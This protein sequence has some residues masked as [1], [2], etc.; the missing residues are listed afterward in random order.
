[1]GKE[2]LLPDVLHHRT[3]Q[4]NCLGD[5]AQ[6]AFEECDSG[7]F[8]RHIRACGHCDSNVCGRERGRIVDAVTSHRHDVALLPELLH[9]LTVILQMGTFVIL[10]FS[11]TLA[12]KL[13][14]HR[15][16]A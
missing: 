9:A 13:F 12:S 8:H 7:A 11:S 3:A 14:H 1:M 2:K 10:L 15:R 4:N 16:D 5:A 6:V